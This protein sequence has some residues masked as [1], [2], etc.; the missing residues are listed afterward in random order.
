MSPFAIDQP[1]LVLIATLNART[2]IA[3][4]RLVIRHGLTALLCFDGAATVASAQ[5]QRQELLGA[6]LDRDLP[7]LD[8]EAVA[9]ALFAEAGLAE[10]L[11]LRGHGPDWAAAGDAPGGRELPQDERARVDMWLGRLAQLQHH[12]SEYPS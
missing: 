6:I 5:A 9:Q 11:L 2:R 1:R 3:L 7:T 10:T 8:G 12:V 4:T